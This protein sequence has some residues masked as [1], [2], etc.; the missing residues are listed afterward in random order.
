MSN[1]RFA[2]ELEE[3]IVVNEISWML[4]ELWSLSAL[5]VSTKLSHEISQLKIEVRALLHDPSPSEFEL[6]LKSIKEMLDLASTLFEQVYAQYMSNLDE[7]YVSLKSRIDEL[8]TYH[9]E[10]YAIFRNRTPETEL[11]NEIVHKSIH[12]VGRRSLYFYRIYDLNRAYQLD[13]ENDK[14]FEELLSHIT[15]ALDSTE[16]ALNKPE[17]LWDLVN[18]LEAQRLLRGDKNGS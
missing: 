15:A 18:R 12:L 3:N 11:L 5:I 7:S 1:D 14:I 16:V 10:A 8:N 4:S 17:D 13:T 6:I 9:K 2:L